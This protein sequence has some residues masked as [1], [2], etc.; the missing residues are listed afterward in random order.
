MLQRDRLSLFGHV[1]ND[2]IY[3]VVKSQTNPDLSYGCWLRADGSYACHTNNLNICGGL[4]NALCKHII[5]VLGQFSIYNEIHDVLREWVRISLNK[6]P[7]NR[8][9]DNSAYI[10]TQYMES[11]GLLLNL[12]DSVEIAEFEM[13]IGIYSYYAPEII[14][15]DSL[16]P[17]WEVVDRQTRSNFQQRV[18]P[19][20]FRQ[21]PRP[22]PTEFHKPRS[23]RKKVR[24]G[25]VKI[26][27]VNN[28]INK[29]R[30]LLN[31][32]KT[33]NGNTSSTSNLE[34]KYVLCIADRKREKIE[35]AKNQDWKMCKV[36][37]YWICLECF[38]LFQSQSDSCV[39][40]LFGF[41]HHSILA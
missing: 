8:N 1:T 30:P 32:H 13:V 25:K 23:R 29:N 18:I 20:E 22:L 15:L 21:Q 28:H 5:V 35:N 31:V 36:C 6:G 27:S 10:F 9:K 17:N 24:E 41:Q 26:I 4:R 11:T 2:T 19:S 39:G 33:V 38:T 16:E 14:D 12:N 37:N 3:G 34:L 7:L 40:S